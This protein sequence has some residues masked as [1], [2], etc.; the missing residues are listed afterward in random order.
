VNAGGGVQDVDI[1]DGVLYTAS[2]SGGVYAFSLDDPA[3][4]AMLASASTAGAAISVSADEGYVWVTNQ[5]SVLV[6]DG[7]DPTQLTPLGVED[8]PSWAMHVVAHG[9]RAYVADWKT[10]TVFE[11]LEGEVAADADVELSSLYFTG[12]DEVRFFAITNRGGADLVIHGLGA[13][14]PRFTVEVD[15]LTVAPGDHATVTLTFAS[16]GEEVA[17]Q[18]CVAT[19]DPDESVQNIELASS[20]SGSNVLIGEA[21]PDFLLTGL[22]GKQYT[23]SSMK[24]HPVVLC[25]FAS[26]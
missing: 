23:L 24:G 20:S 8:T 17:S 22:D 5:E 12:G 10:V 2:G 13:D 11:Y 4:P 15:K 26:W 1:S 25:F 6:F 21:A 16:D 9:N 3:K 14:D 19:N 7:S 18:L